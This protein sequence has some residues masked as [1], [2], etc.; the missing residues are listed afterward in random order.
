MTKEY[1][2]FNCEEDYEHEY[3]ASLF[4]EPAKVKK[5]LEKMCANNTIN[6]TTHIELYEMLVD[7]GF[8]MKED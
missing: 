7:A 1:E 6:N 4:T 3:V 5:W 2:Y 8:T